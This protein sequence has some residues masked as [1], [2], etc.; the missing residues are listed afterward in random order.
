MVSRKRIVIGSRGSRLALWQANFVASQVKR[1][2]SAEVVIE[3]IK[4]RGDKI[5]DVPLAK[6]GG[7]GLFVKEI[8]VA[9]LGNK[10]DL[11]VHS[12]KDV[13]T[14]IP[15]GLV[16][17]A[18]LKREEVSDVLISRENQGLADLPS[19][20][21]VGT[22]SLRRRAQ[23]LNYRPDFS[24]VDVRGNLDTRLRKMGEGKF[25]G[26]IVAAA[27]LIRMGWDGRITERIP[28]DIC[29]PAVGQ[30]AIGLEIRSADEEM[31]E[32]VRQLNDVPTEVAVGAER[33]L[34]KRLQ[35]GC[36]VPLGALGLVENGNLKLTAVVASLDGRRLIRDES[37]GSFS[38]PEEIGRQLADKLLKQ[39]ATEILAEI[40][41]LTASQ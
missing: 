11:A 28:F 40:R 30:G 14:D 2:V 17:G 16:L 35:G 23:L 1:V 12:M 19:G 26:I 21:R 4:T 3:K 33:V 37:G 36:Q 6:V 8:E 41:K 22:S 5:V 29:L 20:A 9:L 15:E 39:G 24:M 18:V 38:K 34:M 10:I 27:G 31:A 13:P 7:E 25:D 32:I